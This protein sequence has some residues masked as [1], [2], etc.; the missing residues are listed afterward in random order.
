MNGPRQKISV[1]ILPVLFFPATCLYA[2]QGTNDPIA[3]Y[4]AGTKQYLKGA[5]AEAEKALSQSLAAAQPALQ[6]RAAY[7]LA[8]SQYKQ[9]VELA[10]KNP[11]GARKFFEQTLENYQLSI[12]RNPHDRDAQYNYELTQKHLE[13][14]KQKEQEQKK[15]Q[16]GKTQGPQGQKG[17]EQETQKQQAQQGQE[18]KEPA[19]ASQPEEKQTG[20]E[21]NVKQAQAAGQQNKEQD[22]QEEKAAVAQAG[23]KKEGEA[24]KELSQQQALWILDNM[25]REEYGARAN[26]TQQSVHESNVDQDW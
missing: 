24:A 12:R 26:H 17:Q 9:G 1:F 8:G 22:K 15:Q 20:K 19:E 7:N 6:A 13:L 2:A 18:K 25:Q 14:V 21:E 5:F 23:E 16:Q 4:N 3:R 11:E 10:L